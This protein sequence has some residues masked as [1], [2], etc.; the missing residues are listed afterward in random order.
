MSPRYVRIPR[1]CELTGYSEKAV[2]RK[3]DEGVWLRDVHYVKAGREVVMDLEGY[4][5]WVEQHR[6]H[7]AA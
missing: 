4:E 5:Q 1:F 3:I 7:R 2:R 6:E